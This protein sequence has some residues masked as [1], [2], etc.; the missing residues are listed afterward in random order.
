MLETFTFGGGFSLTVR[1]T[2]R[3]V[4]PVL[5]KG[6]FCLCKNFWGAFSSRKVN[7]FCWATQAGFCYYIKLFAA[8]NSGC[9]AFSNASNKNNFFNNS[10]A[11]RPPARRPLTGVVPAASFVL[12]KVKKESLLLVFNVL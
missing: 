7:I 10:Q 1:Q 4:Q 8:Q 9:R 3:Q 12:P 2:K 6:K 11:K 5:K